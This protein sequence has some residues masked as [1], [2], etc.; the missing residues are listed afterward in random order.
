VKITVINPTIGEKWSEKNQRFWS[1]A[2]QPGTQIK[3][4]SLEWGTASI[5]SR[6]D[7]ALAAPGILYRALQAEREGADAVVI[8]CMDDPG[9]FAAREAVRIP[10]IGPAQASMHVAAMLAHRFSLIT[11]SSKDIPAIEELIARYGMSGKSTPVR[12]IDIPVL[13]LESD[14]QATVAA[15][16]DVAQRAVEQDGAGVIIP[17]CT[18][19][20]ERIPEIEAGLQQHSLAVRVLNPPRIALRLAENLVSLGLTH[21]RRTYAPPGEKAIRWPV[22][23]PFAEGK[24]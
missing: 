23:R 17:G 15:V 6:L 12:A 18:V 3:V 19:L 2:A 13:K 8:D 1:G 16:V 11:T 14:P 7:D 20:A 5:E 24:L 10:V 9:L 22:E 21:S 4:V